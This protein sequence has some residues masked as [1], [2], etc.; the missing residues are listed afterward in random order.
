MNHFARVAVVGDL[1][2]PVV[3]ARPDVPEER[4]VDQKLVVM[5]VT[6]ATVATGERLFRAVASS[7]H[8]AIAASH[9]LTDGRLRHPDRE[10]FDR[11]SVGPT[12]ML[13]VVA[14]QL[15]RV[16]DSW[17]PVACAHDFQDGG[18]DCRWALGCE[19]RGA[20]LAD[21]Q[22]SGGHLSGDFFD[23]H[24]RSVIEFG[25]EPIGIF[26]LCDAVV[27]MFNLDSPSD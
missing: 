18:K 3:A 25:P 2:L 17:V 24:V 19:I 11:M 7:C 15:E 6:V 8:V 27:F 10:R 13:G 16:C 1:R 22:P 5:M 12:A 26:H 23:R 21:G 9:H 4:Q 14:P 20:L